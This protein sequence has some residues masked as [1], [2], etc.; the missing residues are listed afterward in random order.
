MARGFKNIKKVE[1]TLIQKSMKQSDYERMEKLYKQDTARNIN[2]KICF[3]RPPYYITEKGK[4]W[5]QI[6]KDFTD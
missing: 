4:A 3:K 1:E 6:R 5:N 2:A